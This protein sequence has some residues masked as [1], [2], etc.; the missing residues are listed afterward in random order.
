MDNLSW[1]A[2]WFASQC[3]GEWES[4]YGLTLESVNNPGWALG[5]DLDGTG[6]DPDAFTTVADQ[7]TEHDWVEAKV[8]DGVFHGGCSP[9]NLNELVGIFRAFV[10]SGGGKQARPERRPRG[11]GNGPRGGSGGAGGG[12][13]PGHPL[14]NRRPK[15]PRR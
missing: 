4:D 13:G 2:T 10:E 7:R 15:G 3:D 9:E 11:A 14:G 6:I 5:I 1:L 12:R 8:M